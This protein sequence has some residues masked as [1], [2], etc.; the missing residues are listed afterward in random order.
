MI[1]DFSNIEETVIPRFNGGEKE[2]A[3]RMYVDA[4]NKIMR[5]KLEPGASIG[6]HTHETSSEMIYILAGTGTALCDGQTETLPAGACHYCPKGHS[7]SLINRST[8]P[9]V[10]FAVVPQ[11]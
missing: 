9:L 10:F 4:S 5:G 8:E 3:A 6:L 11:Q 1:V 2:V 7:H